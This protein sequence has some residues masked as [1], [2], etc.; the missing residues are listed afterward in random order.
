M[1]VLLYLMCSLQWSKDDG[2]R[3]A[4]VANQFIPMNTNPKD[5][6]EM[7]NKVSN[8]PSLIL[9]TFIKQLLIYFFIFLKD[10]GAEPAGHKNSRAP[11][12]GSVCRHGGGT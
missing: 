1:S 6:L 12:P 2:I 8:G 5:V 11:V 10:S 7:R 9:V 4:A 3:Q